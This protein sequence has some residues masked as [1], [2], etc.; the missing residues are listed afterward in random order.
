MLEYITNLLMDIGISSTIAGYFTNGILILFILLLSVLGNFIAKKI[1]LRVMTH[2]ITNNQIKWDNIM[3]ERKVFERL[4]HIVPALIIFSFA[5]FFPSLQIWIQRFAAAYII[6]VGIFVTSAFLNAVEDIYRCYEVSKTKPIKSYIQVIKIIVYIIGG[7]LIIGNM[8]GESPFVLLG[9]IGALSAVLILVFK[10]SILG[11]VASIQLSANDMVRI[12]D[13]IEM[14][15][16][17]ADGDVKDITLNIVKVENFDRTITTIPTYALISDS[18]KNWRGMQDS[19]GR[20]IKRSI[21]I[22]TNSIAFCTEEM[23]ERFKKILYL[24]EYITTKQREIEEYNQ[25]LNVDIV[26]LINGRR[27]TNIGTFRIY[28]EQ[29]LKN[30]PKIHKEMIQMVRQLAPGEHGLPI[31]VYVFTNDTDWINYENIQSDIFDHILAVSSQFGLRVFQNPTG[32][33]MR[34]GL[35]ARETD[36]THKNI[37]NKPDNS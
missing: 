31:E 6:I 27:L 28:I 32:Y 1:V 25:K 12:G 13:W 35:G 34:A 7:I 29:Y 3:L 19:G 18:F 30:H 22:D 21:F 11:L 33:D 24:S 14:P 37:Q 5:Q 20:R 2:Y 26:D 8:I 23:I 4:S 10:D 9:G 17:G 36:K 16:Y 15:K